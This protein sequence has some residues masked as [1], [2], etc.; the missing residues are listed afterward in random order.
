MKPDTLASSAATIGCRN[1]LTAF[2]TPPPSHLLVLSSFPPCSSSLSYNT[3][4]MLPPAPHVTT[5]TLFCFFL[6]KKQ[7]CNRCSLLSGLRMQHN[8]PKAS[9]VVQHEGHPR[10]SIADLMLPL[11]NLPKD[12]NAY[13]FP[14]FVLNPLVWDEKCFERNDTEMM[15]DSEKCQ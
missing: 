10:V 12:T 7:P 9:T 2:C 1:A 4:A 3:T 14:S 13:S 8:N 5:K 6:Q 11:L 15:Q